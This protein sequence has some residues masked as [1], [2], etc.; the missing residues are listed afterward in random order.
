V[1]DNARATRNQWATVPAM[2]QQQTSQTTSELGST[3]YLPDFCN[4]RMAFGVVLIAEL[5]AL[6]LALARPDTGLGFWTELA[7]ISL[8][9]LWIAL[10]TA[11]ALCG[12]RSWLS[13]CS[14]AAPFG[15]A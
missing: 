5:V 14:P 2:S 7:R 4:A 3:S 6:L 15:V 10:G 11:A 1:P 13:H 12:A 8:L 9:L